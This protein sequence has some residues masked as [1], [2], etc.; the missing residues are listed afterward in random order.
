MF[1]LVPIIVDCGIQPVSCLW[2]HDGSILAVAGMKNS[3]SDKDINQVMFYSAFGV[4][5]DIYKYIRF[6]PKV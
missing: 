3:M 1:F 2:N 5:S 4:V 6:A